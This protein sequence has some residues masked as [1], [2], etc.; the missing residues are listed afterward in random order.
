MRVLLLGK[1]GKLGWELHRCLFSLVELQ[2]V[3]YPRVNLSNESEVRDLIRTN[4]PHLIINAAAYTAVDRAESEQELAYS[5]NTIAP[6]VLAEEAQALKAGVIHYST[7]YV[8]DGKKD[9]PYT[10]T[11]LPNPLNVYGRSK[12]LGERAI[13]SKINT[14]LILRTAWVY[15][16][17]RDSFVTKVLQ[18]ARQ[19]ETLKIVDDQ[20]SNPTWARILAECTVHVLVKGISDPVGYIAEHSGLYHIA[21]D[22]FASRYEWACEILR[23][24]SKKNAS[25]VYD[26]E[27]TLS[28]EFPSPAQRPSFSALDSSLFAKIFGIRCGRWQKLLELAMDSF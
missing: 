4:R 5:I 28:S 27:P 20:I 1:Q 13:Q 8:F 14:Y 12:L 21:G 19:S 17:R 10:E 26:I 3:D 22:G 6:G 7:D 18:W 23:L 9:V 16:L 15:S 11:D 2:T 25:L 24:A